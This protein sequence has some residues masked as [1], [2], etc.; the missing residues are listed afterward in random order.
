MDVPVA[1][2]DV[3]NIKKVSI[4]IIAGSM[5]MVLSEQGTTVEP[6]SGWFFLQKAIEAWMV[7]VKESSSVCFRAWIFRW[8]S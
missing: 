8:L 3:A 5:A 7:Q 1:I 2:D 4:I 6:C